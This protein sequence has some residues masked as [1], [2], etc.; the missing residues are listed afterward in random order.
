MSE[1]WSIGCIPYKRALTSPD[2]VAIIFEDIPVTYRKLNEGINKTAHMLEKKGIKKGDRAGL[3]MLN[4]VEFLE[5]YFAC[6][7]LGAI[8]VPL[9]W[10][11]V[12]PGT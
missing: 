5:I 1:D 10:R 9:N 6:A 12:G 11:L 7:K 4:C 3:V 2:K 8:L